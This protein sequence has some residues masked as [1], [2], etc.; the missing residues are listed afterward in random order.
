MNPMSHQ[1]MSAGVSWHQFIV[2]SCAS[3]F[4]SLI[5]LSYSMA[6]FSAKSFG[7]F[8]QRTVDESI[9]SELFKSTVQ[10]RSGAKVKVNVL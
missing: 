6:V 9:V 8:F 5:S 3:H 4:D 10:L 7:L 2:E 1:L